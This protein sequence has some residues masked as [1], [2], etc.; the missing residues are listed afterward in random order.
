MKHSHLLLLVF[1]IGITPTISAQA[2]ADRWQLDAAQRR[3]RWEVAADKRLPHLDRIEVSGQ[4]T[5]AW[6]TYGADAER[7][8][9]LE[10]LCVWPTLRVAPNDTHSSLTVRF[11]RDKAPEAGRRQGET[12]DA[13]GARRFEPLLLLDGQV[14]GAEK[15]QW[16]VYRDGILRLETMPAEGVQL[17]RELCPSR[18]GTALLE[19]WTI[20]NHRS[21]PV[22]VAAEPCRVIC[23]LPFDYIE[24][25]V[26]RNGR[27]TPPSRHRRGNYRITVDSPG[28]PATTLAS[29][30]AAVLDLV[31][32]AARVG[33]PESLFSW[34]AEYRRRRELV[35]GL[36]RSL[37]LECPD[38]VLTTMFD[39]SKIRACDSI[40]ATPHGPMHAPGGAAYYAA[41]WANDTVEYV[42][43][44]YPFL[45][46]SYGNRASLNAFAHFSRYLNP[47]YHPLPSSIIA[48]GTDIWNGA[49]DR[50]DQAMLAYGVSRFLLALGDPA[51]ARRYWPLVSWCL[52]YLERQKTGAGV[53]ASDTDELEGRF[54]AGKINLNT[55]ML[56]YGG[57]LSAADLADE[58]GD[59]TR[60]A[61]YRQRAAALR[62]AMENFFG[63]DVRGFPTYRYHD[64][65]EELRAWICMP[66]TMGVFDRREGTLAALFSPRLWTA[67]GLLTAEGSTTFWDRST[68]YALRGV[69]Y[70]GAADTA[71]PYLQALS[72]RRLLGEHVPY[73]VEAYPEGNGRHLS[74]ES[75]LY[76][77][78]FTEGLF[79]MVPR[80]FRRLS[81]KPSLPSAWASMALRDIRACAD[82]FDLEVHRMRKGTIRVQVLRHGRVILERLLP[83][84][85]TP[86][87]MLTL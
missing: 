63:A 18:L 14:C 83:E 49:G 47:E 36:Y 45:G 86:E 15:L 33:D 70:S 62:T 61:V 54:T 12:L 11:F 72:R 78:I 5:A 73:M 57:L 37:R 19:R 56:T 55:N 28:L 23:T 77:R 38:P 52:E 20:V 41:I 82:R 16:A 42:A 30:R 3:I 87:I 27:P 35:H 21:V 65:L 59:K 2:A 51:A 64:G 6:I 44:L 43:P 32:H 76:C 25:G 85:D 24:K 9:V 81:L 29:G 1:L 48:G 75:A 71:L 66:L 39:F 69:F 34:T 7:R 53:I 79:G 60:A 10:R 74:A 4:R 40:V 22:R 84:N 67:D 58:L 26:Y 8:L 50:G 13:G 31:F 46:F 17:I 68:L 80:G